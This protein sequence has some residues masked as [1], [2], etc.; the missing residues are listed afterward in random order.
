MADQVD[1]AAA[2]L[3]EDV[4]QRPRTGELAVARRIEPNPAGA[5]PARRQ[6]VPIKADDLIAGA[7]VQFPLQGAI[8]DTCLAGG[9]VEAVHQNEDAAALRQRADSLSCL[10]PSRSIACRSSEPAGVAFKQA[11]RPP[12]AVQTAYLAPV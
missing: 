1:G 8:G 4:P 12:E 2:K 5:D 7:K 11:V 6:A 9:V 10:S 3:A